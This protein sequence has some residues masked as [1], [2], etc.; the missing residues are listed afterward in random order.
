M[1]TA[2]VIMTNQAAYIN[3]AHYVGRVKSASSEIK[4]TTVKV[5]GLGGVGSIDVPN[6]KFEPIT[7]SVV[8]E[9]LA[10]ADI[11]RLNENGGFVKLRLTGLVKV[12]DSHTGLRVN[13]S[14]TTRIHGFVTNPPTPNYTDE[15]Q[16]YT[17][18]ISV[19]FIEVSDNGGQVFMVDFAKGICYPDAR[20]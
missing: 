8:F 1:S 5:G 4:R 19:A 3:E 17:A 13:G 10:P 18:N 12:L 15:S 9:Q 2:S 16:D 11:R 6:G 20:K 14:M 7:A